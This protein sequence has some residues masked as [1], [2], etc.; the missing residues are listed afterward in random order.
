MK[1][2][3]LRG[4]DN[5]LCEEGLIGTGVAGESLITC[6]TPAWSLGA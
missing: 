2:N 4:V 1:V 3:S 6:M 5:Y